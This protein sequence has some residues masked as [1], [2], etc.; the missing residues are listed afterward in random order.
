MTAEQQKLKKF[1]ADNFDFD[2]LK[3]VGFWPQ[4]TRKTDFELQAARVCEFFGY[5]SVYEYAANQVQIT[6][7]ADAFINGRFVDTIDKDGNLHTGEGFHMS[8]VPTAFDCP[9]CTMKQDANDYAAFRNGN[10]VVTNVKCK[11]CK[12][13][14]SL[15]SLGM[16][17]EFLIVSER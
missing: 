17:E 4:G 15:I 13:P 14:I 12:R 16:G 3:Q 1:M 8:V 5:D 2:S 10:N 9:C 6:S 11:G 7:D